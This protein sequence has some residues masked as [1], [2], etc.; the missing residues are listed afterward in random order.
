MCIQC[1]ILKINISNNKNPDW[2]TFTCILYKYCLT[3]FGNCYTSPNG[4]LLCL[5]KFCNPF[6]PPF[7]FFCLQNRWET[8]ESWYLIDLF[9][10]CYIDVKDCIKCRDSIGKTGRMQPFT[11][12][13]CVICK[14]S[15]VALYYSD[16]GF[17]TNWMPFFAFLNYFIFMLQKMRCGVLS[18]FN[19][20]MSEFLCNFFV[21]IS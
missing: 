4:R 7:F 18:S 6:P 17:C 2:L 5:R 19:V 10:K 12:H 15:H 13:H 16:F 3:R 9:N 20:R 11:Q 8:K 21:C 14:D 1:I